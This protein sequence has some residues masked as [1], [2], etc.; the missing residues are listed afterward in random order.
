MAGS[1]R[2]SKTGA[3]GDR[4]KEATKINLSLSAL[5]NCISSLV[6]GKS[7]HIPYRDSKLTRLLQSSLGGNAKTLMIATF[8][9]AS[10]NY[11]E[12]I[13]TLR[14]ANRAKSIKNQPV[15]NEDPK[16][17]MLRQF[18]EEIK[19][20]KES[21]K[22]Q[23]LRGYPK[24][25]TKS[26]EH[27]EAEDSDD[28]NPLSIIDADT[29]SQLQSVIKSEKQ[30]LIASK[31]MVIEEKNKISAEL[32]KRAADVESEKLQRE[33]L[34]RKLIELEDKLL[35]GGVH[36]LVK[37]SEQELLLKSTQNTLQDQQKK[38]RELQS[39][40]D[41]RQ[42]AKLQLEVNCSSLQDEVELKTKNLSKVWNMYQASKDEVTSAK[43]DLREEREELLETIRDLT[44][45]ILLI[46]T[47]TKS[48]IPSNER[49]QLERRIVFD[50][51]PGDSISAKMTFPQ[52]E[53]MDRV[54]LIPTLKRPLCHYAKQSMVSGNPRY[55]YDNV[56]NV[57]LIIPLRRTMAN[58]VSTCPDTHISV[59]QGLPIEPRSIMPAR[60][61]PRKKADRI[62]ELIYPSSRADK[63]PNRY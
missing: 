33:I 29:I 50:E 47:I 53:R 45:E 27:S 16:D 9:P 28:G 42:N 30:K 15:I 10:Y 18:Q 8:S 25:L 39:K 21:L 11:E 34:S 37:V 5:G 61:S 48:F 19:R 49:E 3:T 23:K 17:A 6:D 63:A 2:Q 32:D 41:D 44:K 22:I 52:E 56:I 14:Y 26:G 13:S 55:R 40:I 58:E 24:P 36:I 38:Q 59:Y 4:L 54:C 60:S 7:T 57:P 43:D 12:T 46:Q 31:D 20:L 35:I 51:S 1:E 62:D